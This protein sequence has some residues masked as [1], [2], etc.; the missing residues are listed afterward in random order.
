MFLVGW[1][2]VALAGVTEHTYNFDQPQV[3]GNPDG[4]VLVL[5]EGTEQDDATPGWPILPIRT[6]KLVIPAG[7]TVE[8][9]QVTTPEGV[10]LGQG[11]VVDHSRGVHPVSAEG[12]LHLAPPDPAIYG[13]DQDFPASPYTDRGV[14]RLV[15]YQVVMVELRPVVY[16]P[17]RGEL[18]YFPSLT[19]TVNT[20]APTAART[21]AA[22]G[23]VM[24]RGAAGD[25]ARVLNFVDNGEDLAVKSGKGA[26]D[27]DSP[28]AADRQYLIITTAALAAT[29]QPLADFR[30][31]PTGGSYTTYIETVE[32]IAA[33][34]AGVDLAEKIRNYLKTSY[35]NHGTQYVVLGGDADGPAS[36]VV[37][38]RGCWASTSGYTDTN[39]PSDLYF[40]CLD[41]TWNNNNNAYWGESNDGVGGGDIDW[42]PELYVGRICADNAT[43]AT[44]Q[45]NKII[46]YESNPAPF[47]T[48]LL[49]E[50][51]DSTPTYGG[52]KMDWVY[53]FMDGMPN[54]KLYDKLGNFSAGTLVSHINS[55]SFDFINHLGHSNNT[56]GLKIGTSTATGLT[57][58]QYMLV[59]T[60]GCYSAAFDN[61]GTGTSYYS[62]ATD[63]LAEAFTTGSATGGAYAFIGNSRYGWYNSGTYLDGAS[64]RL[65]RMFE[66]ELFSGN[67]KLGP[68]NEISKTNLSMV[69]T[70]RWIAFETNLFG[71][72]ASRYRV[73]A[74]EELPPLVSQPANQT[75][76]EHLAFTGPTPQLTQGT[77]PITWSLVAGPAGMS[78]DPA[79]GVV[80]WADPVV[81]GSPYTVTLRATNAF[82]ADDRSFT[83]TVFPAVLPV[84]NPIANTLCGEG[85]AYTGPT[86]SLSQ[87][88]EPI[89]WSLVTGP[90]GMTINAVTGVVSWA[91]PTPLGSSHTV[92]IRVTNTKG[93]AT[94]SWTLGVTQVANLALNKTATQISTYGSVPKVAGLAVD[95]DTNGVLSAGTSSCTGSDDQPWWQV[96]LGESCP[97]VHI[98]LWNRTDA[99]PERLSNYYVLVSD[100]PFGNATL[101]QALAIPGVWSQ[102]NTAT[103]GSPTSVTVNR[104]GR[105]VRVQL[106]QTLYLTLPEVQVWGFDLTP[107]APVIAALSNQ[108]IQT[109]AAYTGPTPSLT[110]GGEPITWSLVSGPAGMSIN[111]ATGVVSW[112][113]PTTVGS[114]HT[115]TIRASNFGGSGQASWNLTVTAPVAPVIAAIGDASLTASDPYTGPTPS[116][117]AGSEPITWS[118]TAGP[119]GMSIDAVTGVVSWANPTSVGS[120]HAVTIQATN[121]VGSDTESW[122]LTVT[123]DS[124]LALNKTA[125]QISTYGSIPKAAALAVDGDSNGVFSAGTSSCTNGDSQPWW[126][127]DLGSS[128]TIKRIDIFNRTDAMPERLSN[129]YVL[130]SDTP[131]GNA[132]LAQAL[133][134]PGVWSQFNTATAGSP[135]SVTV[136]RSGRYVR[137]QLTQTQYLTLA[138]VQV[139]GTPTVT[140][141]PSINPLA[142]ITIPAGVA[143]TSQAPTLAAGDAP[144]TWSLVSGPAGM[145][146][147][148]ASGAVSWANPTSV[149]SPHTV[150]M[151]ATNASGSDDETWYLTVTSGVA[152]VINALS[153]AS[154]AAGSP[155]T[156]PT[157]SLAAGTAPITWSLTAGPAGMTI[158]AG[159]GVVSWANPS[160]AGSASLVTLQATN[161]SGSD[162]KSFTLS[163]TGETNLALNK[164]A[165]Q[166]ST[167]GSIPKEASLAV[168]GDTNGVFSAGTSSCTNGDSQPWWQ[169]DLGAS[170]SISRIDLWNRTDAMPER[171][172]NYYVLVS[173]TPFGNATLAQALALPGVWAQLNVA[174]AGSPTSVTVN[175][176]G[177]YVRVQLTQTKYLTL[178]EVQVW[179]TAGAPPAPVVA[180]FGDHSTPE[181]QAYTS[182][183]PT[184]TQG[185]GVTWSL[186]AGPA[187]MTINAATGA[188]SWANP[189]TVGSPHTVTMRAANASGS[190]TET[191]TLNVT[192]LSNLALNKT[193]TQIS[194]FGSVPKIAGL[195]VDGD[196]NGIFSTGTSSCTG[197]D[198]QPW[199][200]VDLGSSAA[201]SHIDLWN[202]TDA[203]PERLSNYYVMVSDTPFGNA[204]LTQALAIPGV[205]SKFNAA[206]AGSP[207]AVAVNR[208]GR[209]VRVQLTQTT[210]LTLAEVQV[211]GYATTAVN[212]T[213]PV[214]AGPT[215]ATSGNSATFTITCANPDAHPRTAQVT[216]N[217]AGH[218]ALN[219]TLNLAPGGA[220][221]ATASF[222]W[223]DPGEKTVQVSV[224]GEL[225]AS[226]S[227]DISAAADE[228]VPDG[229]LIPMY[230]T[231]STALA[232]HFFTTSRKEFENAV[233]YGGY[234]DESTGNRR[235]FFVVNHAVPGTA[236]ICRLYNP[237]T[238]R[239]YY[240]YRTSERDTLVSLGW[241]YEHGEGFIFTQPTAGGSEI[242]KLYNLNTGAHLYTSNPTEVEYILA[243]IPGWEQHRSLGYAFLRPN[244]LAAGNSSALATLGLI[245]FNGDGQADRV[246]YNSSNGEVRL[247][248]AGREAAWQVAQADGTVSW[249]LK[250]VADF[251][252]DGK[253]DLLWQD[254]A[255]GTVAIWFMDGLTV[256][257]QP[258]VGTLTEQGWSLAQLLDADHD[259]Q[260]DILWRQADSGKSS[261]WLMDGAVIRDLQTY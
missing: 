194:T 98:D 131:F 110:T 250:G 154:T 240:T 54:T 113:S 78:I 9:I 5:L 144:V 199:W 73:P 148:A 15:G 37:P 46:A 70:Y 75:Q 14:Q 212:T 214:L 162:S 243:N 200:Q 249:L 80:S 260:A 117:T 128:A 183:A 89:T 157:P 205:W 72:P 42:L 192:S 242:Y 122:Q 228:P 44:N 56:Y 82:G 210:Y 241:N 86:P 19:V 152:P 155:Y 111:A 3:A 174:T 247:T 25:V 226:Q 170:A 97:I 236:Q 39:I 7:E 22:D 204:T 158:N 203:V 234:Q 133:A 232:Y 61:R 160:P 209:Y 76:V 213:P 53:S 69:T 150:T 169:V 225:K 253:S 11:F 156:G 164:T 40:A 6:A 175:R 51:M 116:L 176:S 259:Q 32:N 13:S 258:L 163:V 218:P 215:A 231:Y 21:Q 178:A 180:A 246:A 189:T 173:D 8:A 196:T 104:S 198:P 186:A 67:T 146:I 153:D 114:P 129:Y 257:S 48:L 64:N 101:A 190:D 20:S 12:P 23:Q 120:P 159:T 161:A 59:Y 135:T 71:D 52:D 17:V 141:A 202:R 233:T 16:N 65:H 211:W 63:S 134:I 145:T 256:S 137:V 94:E 119:A 229:Y 167:Y 106:T 239:H 197:G 85:A 100:T 92:T 102:F 2:S 222:T 138:E 107:P 139:W 227:V 193:A 74:F 90:A 201:I 143:W 43:E 216:W 77:P 96:D 217:A 195:A 124:N 188:V 103:A 165:T 261:L 147:N 118:L 254:P 207:T 34:Q 181:G 132:T 31:T 206:T 177:R 91:N 33:S 125:T 45:I 30:A 130:V 50:L 27:L 79:T 88:T 187:G 66:Q 191:W 230:R 237:N 238:G 136:N 208:S 168:D 57:N 251:D 140:A 93:S 58:G 171:L 99:V 244:G 62:A 221:Q 83:L 49:G 142:G 185:S 235:L 87:G 149:G 38:T 219:Q 245:D 108:S 84:I 29:F 95:G 224:D 112:A 255:S 26:L 248:V 184:L 28:A 35:Q 1:G 179:G 166:I 18:R 115:I 126:Q 252:G 24:A 127:V 60:Q 182:S 10:S 123:G 121:S 68:A 172:S 105:Y 109:G 151:R 47:R 55:N 81:T 4:S 220:A 36:Q 223:G 41:G